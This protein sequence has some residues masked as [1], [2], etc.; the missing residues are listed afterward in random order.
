MLFNLENPLESCELKFASDD[1]T[2]EFAGY[3]SVWD[4]TD[5]GGDTI[6]KGAFAE[7]IGKRLP[8][9]FINHRHFDIPPGDWL[10][11]KEDDI[12]L[13]TEGKIDL[14]HR[15]GPSLYSAMKRKAMTGLSIG[16]PR[17]SMKF[18]AK[19]GGG[20]LITYA[21]LREVSV[22][23]FPMEESAQIMAV[24]SDIETIDSLKA[25]EL[26]LRDSGAFS[27][28]TATAFVSQLKSL[29]QSDSDAELRE[30]IAE[31]KSRLAGSRT[32]AQLAQALDKYDIRKLVK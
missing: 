9:M 7:A 15:E 20:R 5:L 4:S 25:A 8:K 1:S 11:A 13:Y 24:K 12:G 30:Q 16:F 10:S 27:R 29:C 17:K 31:L 21:D 23:T 28:A 3:A 6:Q 32:A 18:T 19:D 14:N 22:V 26:L 2:G